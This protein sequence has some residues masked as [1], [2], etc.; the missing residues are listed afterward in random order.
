MMNY[1]AAQFTEPATQVRQARAILEFL[2]QSVRNPESPFARQLAEEV[3]ELGDDADWYLYHE[4]LESKNHPFYFHEFA[5]NV[6]N[7]GLQYLASAYFRS[8]D[9]NL[10]PRT[11]SILRQVAPQRVRREQYIDFLCNT[12]F[13][14]SLVCQAEAAVREPERGRVEGLLVRALARPSAVSPSLA[15][16]A[17]EEF[18]SPTGDTLQTTSPIVKALLVTLDEARPRALGLDELWS[19]SVDRLDRAGIPHDDERTELPEI[20]LRAAQSNLVALHAHEPPMVHEGSE[21]PLVSPWA[22]LQA[23]AGD[24]VTSQRHA[25]VR[26]SDAERLVL[27]QLDGRHDRPALRA[28][29]AAGFPTE[30]SGRLLDDCL[31]RFAVESLLLG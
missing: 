9:Q 7:A 31:A 28:A 15:P 24:E 21:R 10:P 8:W 14:R 25:R 17:E 29:L 19:R 23:E 26:L 2:V 27:R 4:Y 12:P 16:D 20:V 3:A 13:R 18:R 30:D 22:R 5:A 6:Q 1:H 11:E